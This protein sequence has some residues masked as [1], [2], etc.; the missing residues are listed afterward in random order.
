MKI[1][2]I[3]FDQITWLDLI[4]VY[5]P[6]TRLRSMG[7]LKNLSWDFC[8]FSGEA[9]DRFGLKVIPTHIKQTLA[10]YDV[11]IVPGGLGTRALCLDQDFIQWLKTAENASYKISVC[12]GS[13][14]LGAAGFLK[15]KKATTNFK[16]YETLALYCQEVV[17]SRI[18]EDGN[19]ITAGAVASSLDLGLYLCEKW[20]GPVARE[21]IR[22][23]M[24]YADLK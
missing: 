20:A 14:L 9:A 22:E 5:D 18:V 12:T 24:A 3:I 16:E 19:V 7:F 6:I 8:A 15:N 17:R 1:A 2:F 13:L 21:N 4:G 11:L 23:S 10:A